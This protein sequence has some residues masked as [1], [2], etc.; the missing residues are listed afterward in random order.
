M[1]P[2]VQDKLREIEAICRRNSVQR[3]FV[4]GSAATGGF[5]PA[6]SDIDFLVVFDSRAVRGGLDDV[7]FRL[8]EELRTLFQREVDLVE[9]RALQNPYLISS[10]NR[11]KRMLYAA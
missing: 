10:V 3:L 11:T 1:A 9:A 4:F 5:D 6:K 7:Y 2:V 8:L